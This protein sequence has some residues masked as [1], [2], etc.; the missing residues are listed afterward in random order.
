MDEAFGDGDQQL[1]L[2]FTIPTLR[3]R[4][5]ERERA[6]LPDLAKM[7]QSVNILK[8][9]GNCLRVYLIFGKMLNHLWKIFN[10]I[11]HIF[12]VTDWQI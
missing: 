1:N 12:I 11:G 3:E 4:E 5:R 10:A 2:D 6:V 9:F 7:C 8:V